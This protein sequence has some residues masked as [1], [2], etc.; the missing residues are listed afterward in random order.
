MNRI[1]GRHRITLI[2]GCRGFIHY[3]RYVV[4]CLFVVDRKIVA[5]EPYH[6]LVGVIWGES[7]DL[8]RIV[9]Y[10]GRRA[11]RSLLTELGRA[12]WAEQLSRRYRSETVGIA[13]GV[14]LAIREVDE[15]IHLQELDAM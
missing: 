7:E 6:P 11:G 5:F 15:V 12:G 1:P 10:R 13:S 4:F 8:D 3:V 2:C 14:L 9:S